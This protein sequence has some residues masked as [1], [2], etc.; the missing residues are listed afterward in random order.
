MFAILLDYTLNG[1]VILA[2]NQ[3]PG[4]RRILK[5]IFLYFS[6]FDDLMLYNYH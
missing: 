1:S 4:A 2:A 6:N 3:I 5:P